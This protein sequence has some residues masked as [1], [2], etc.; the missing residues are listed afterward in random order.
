MKRR[1]VLIA[2][3]SILI[4]SSC[5]KDKVNLD[6]HLVLLKVDYTTYNLEGG[7]MFDLN[8]NPT[9]DT[10]Q[11]GIEY[12]EP[13]D[14][15]YIKLFHIPDSTLIFD[16]SILWSGTGLQNF[17]DSLDPISNFQSYGGNNF[18]IDS[19]RIVEV[20]NMPTGQDQQYYQYIWNEISSLQI[21]HDA[22][23]QNFDFSI[24]CYT[25]SVG[26]GAPI[27]WDFFVFFYVQ[28]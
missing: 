5:R 22:Y 2:F 12:E 6:T 25:P 3:F 15:G 26:I 20:F 28:G 9:S 8:S 11:I 23:N 21:V 4:L 7:M 14:L 27:E 19:T 13:A 18:A 17:P 1:Y 10:V 24:F 16:G